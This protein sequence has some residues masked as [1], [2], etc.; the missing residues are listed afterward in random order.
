MRRVGSPESCSQDAGIDASG[1]KQIPKAPGKRYISRGTLVAYSLLYTTPP[2]ITN[3]T[4]SRV[5][6]SCKGSPSTA[7]MSA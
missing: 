5:V 2:F 7:M 6:T 4:R 3:F 1:F